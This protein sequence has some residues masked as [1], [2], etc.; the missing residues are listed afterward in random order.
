M[1]A[2]VSIEKSNYN[3]FAIGLMKLSE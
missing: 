3:T 2:E 1:L